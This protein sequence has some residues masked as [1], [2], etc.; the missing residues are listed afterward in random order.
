MQAAL[1]TE[2]RRGGQSGQEGHRSRIGCA[3]RNAPAGGQDD[4]QGRPTEP[5]GRAL[6]R[7]TGQHAGQQLEG[8]SGEQIIGVGRPEWGAPQRKP[9]GDQKQRA[10]QP[11]AASPGQEPQKKRE[12]HIKLFFD[13]QRPEMQQGIVD[14][15]GA[16]VA[17][18]GGLGVDKIGG[19]EG[20][21]DQD[22]PQVLKF[23]GQ[24]TKPA[25]SCG[26]QAHRQQTRKQ[27]ANAAR[28]EVGQ[29]KLTP[30]QIAQD[31]LRNQVAGNDEKDVHT[32]IAA[33]TFQ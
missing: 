21:A 18:F 4:Q 8:T 13:R 10:Q 20:L 12:K 32:D 22:R 19:Q 2:Q 17:E 24:H 1:A 28:E 15:G 23:F 9:V 11:H 16:E 5:L 25:Q 31:Q 30:V 14:G 29:G 33:V 3:A 6:W 7:Q 27:T 26:H